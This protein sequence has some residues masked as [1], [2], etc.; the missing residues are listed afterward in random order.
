MY[1]TRRARLAFLLA[2]PLL[3]AG[4]VLG[5]EV[6]YNDLAEVG[7]NPLKHSKFSSDSRCGGRGG[8][9]GSGISC[10]PET[11]PFELALMSA[12]GSEL[13]IDGE[14]NV[15]LRLSNIGRESALVPWLTDPEQVELPDDNGSFE[16]SQIDLRADISQEGSRSAYISIPVHLYGAKKVP[17]SLQ[18]IRPGEYVE[19]RV[20]LV[21]DSENEELHFRSLKAGPARL[22]FTWTEWD[23]G[24][25]YE[26]C[27]IQTRQ[28]RI[29][30]LTSDA[31]DMSVVGGSVSE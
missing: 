25:V 21:L 12:E 26:R 7:A 13:A 10:P 11:Y 28:T 3:F 5:Q 29:R 9:L 8:G 2:A 14:V 22:S 27:G 4:S 31:T 15:A 30:Q 1:Y 23:S 20:R 17:G 24:V 19:I 16:F 18:E 6:G